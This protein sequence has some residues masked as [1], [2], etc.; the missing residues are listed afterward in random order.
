[1]LDVIAKGK[2]DPKIDFSE[3]LKTYRR[4]LQNIISVSLDN[5][6]EE[7][8]LKQENVVVDKSSLKILKGS[9]IDYKEELIGKSFKIT[10]P[11]NKSSCGC[12][13]SF[14]V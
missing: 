14:S 6:I 4:N 10:N 12:G 2:I 8:D 9:L 5:K 7:N 1:M 3:G 13:I 11:N